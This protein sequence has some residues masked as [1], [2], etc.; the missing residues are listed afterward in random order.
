[1]TVFEEV[2]RDDLPLGTKMTR[3]L[4]MDIGLGALTLYERTVECHNG[5][6]WQPTEHYEDGTMPVIVSIP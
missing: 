6:I 1:M 4:R 5:P 2:T 3:G